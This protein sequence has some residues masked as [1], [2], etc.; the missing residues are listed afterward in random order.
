MTDKSSVS[1]L[2][3]MYDE[4]T[5]KWYPIGGAINTGSSYT[6]SASQRF[7]NQIIADDVIKA[8]AGVNNFGNESERDLAIPSPVRGL[9]CFIKQISGSDVNQIQFFDG[10]RWRAYNDSVS[11]STK[12]SDYTLAFGDAGKTIL[13]SSSSDLTL[14]IP[15]N[16]SVAFPVETRLD[17][18][19]LGAGEVSVLGV[20]GV[21]VLSKN[22]NYK[23]AARY[24]GATLI[25]TES[26]TWV[27]VGDLYQPL[28]TP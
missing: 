5:D 28:V 27:L 16:I 10:T 7:T 18:V 13:M 23:I 15:S 17:I 11:L 26:N 9:V 2:A 19:R 25:K 12:T 8:K 24:S 14:Y 22:T 6:W 1:K 4:Q 21:T 20:S 3:Y